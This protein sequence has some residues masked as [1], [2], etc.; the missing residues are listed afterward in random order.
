[1]NMKLGRRFKFQQ[2]N[3]ARHEAQA[4][5]EWLNKKKINV[6]ECPSQSSDLT[7]IEHLWRVLKISVLQRSPSNLVE[8]E[9][10]SREEWANISPSHCGKRVE[11]YP[12]R[13]TAVIAAKG[14]STRY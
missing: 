9:Q 4:T 5:L 1:M 14:A 12:K 13:L 11:T 8:L 3:D 10:F 6:L 2:D 7:P